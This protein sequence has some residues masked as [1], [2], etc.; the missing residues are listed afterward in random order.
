MGGGAYRPF[1][2]GL[3]FGF[4]ARLH[5]ERLP[6]MLALR[7]LGVSAGPTDTVPVVGLAEPETKI[8]M[9]IPSQTNYTTLE[10]LVSISSLYSP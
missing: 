2:A 5:L 9:P 6:I 7:E 10:T 8:M 1:G 4:V 3:I